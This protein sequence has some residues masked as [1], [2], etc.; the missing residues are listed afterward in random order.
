[1][2][3][4]LHTIA[5]AALSVA[6]LPAGAAHA[7]DM[8]MNVPVPPGAAV[9]DITAEGSVTR[10]PDMATIR[11]G[12]VTQGDTAASALSANSTR[13]DAVLKALKK[14]G[15]ADRD[16]Q[17]AAIQ[18]NPQYKYGDNQ[19]PQITGYEATNTV[20]IRFR[21]VKRAG[22][23]L[24]ALVGEGANQIQ[25]P[26]L[27]VDDREAAEDAARSDAIAKAR[28]RAAL[29]AKASGLSVDRIV[30]IRETG[31]NYA[32]RPMIAMRA[33]SAKASTQIEPGEQDVTVNV[34]VRFLLK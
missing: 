8:T 3:N 32:P 9:L 19:P 16:V 1:M 21:D 31:S 25:G 23:I 24:D 12:V 13:M 4:Y 2:R 14:A 30:W 17:T 34:A 27:S 28:A 29:Y 7:Q 26:D 5:A 10:T 6:L 15:I 22:A 33:E 18:L 20:T 11:A